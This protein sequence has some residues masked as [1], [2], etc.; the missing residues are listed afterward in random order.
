VSVETGYLTH[1]AQIFAGVA[2]RQPA[3]VALRWANGREV[4]YAQLD[5]GATRLAGALAAARVGKRQT[6]AIATDKCDV[7]YAAMLACLKIGAPYFMV[8]PASPAAR[9]RAIVEQCAPAYAVVGAGAPEVFDC[10]THRIASG[11]QVES[12]EALPEARHVEAEAIDGSDPAYIMFTSGSTGT[13]KGATI[14]QTNLVN[15]IAWARTQYDIEP[16]D[17]VTNVNP[18]YFDNSVFDVYS[19]LFSGATL[20]PF[21]TA[22]LSEPAALLAAFDRLGCTLYFS[23][24][25]LLVYL[26]RLKLIGPGSF[27]TMRR[28][29]FGGEGYPK[30]MLQRLFAAI[31]DRVE[32]HNVYGPTECTCICSSYRITAADFADLDGYP[33][34]GRLIANF[35]YV[36]A[37][38]EGHPVPAGTVGELYLG[39]PCVGLGYYASP[40]QTAAAFVQNPA[41]TR[42]HD[43]MYRTGDLVR[44]DPADGKL[45]FAGRADSQIKLQG[46]RI[47]LG[48]I[49]HAMQRLA[50]VQEAAAIFT[51][52][53]TIARITGVAAGAE[54]V[55]DAMRRDLATL[56]PRYMIPDRI[57]VIDGLPKNANGKIDRP[58]LKSA[59]QRGEL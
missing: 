8:D 40:G 56:L 18:L 20:A 27:K 55:A 53:G 44:L 42:F 33:P 1:A 52:D 19:S 23:V 50:G 6:V 58:A 7:A 29:V 31:G 32:L 35:S 26:Q 15:F 59:I 34:L 9:A 5:R 11:G 25:S 46:Y 4:S 57:V 49:E 41:H 43:R 37:D 45:H 16:H 10:P 51:N 39:G 36:I 21:G 30:P 17:V 48:E 24:P 22:D 28:I 3:A 14:S 38:D 47:E 2:A 12:L 54:V 13:P